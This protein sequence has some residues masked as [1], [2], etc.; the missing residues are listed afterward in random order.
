MKNDIIRFKDFS[1]V[2][3]KDSLG[4][5]VGQAMVD[6]EDVES[7]EK[8][9]WHLIN[10]GYVIGYDDSNQTKF[11]LHNYLMGTKDGF[12]IDH[13]NHN[14]LDCRKAN[15]R[16]FTYSQNSLTARISKRNSSG[17]KGV[18]LFTTRRG[19]TKY[20]AQITVRGTSY[21]LGLHDN[22][23]DAV[24]ARQQ[25]ELQHLGFILDY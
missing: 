7:V 13:I 10:S 1:K 24:E 12:I 5:I 25:A 18:T 2:I 9:K 21:N 22:F 16:Y 15:L 4:V 3:L 6:N 11:L 14:K 20:K 8:H 17:K 23:E 19:I